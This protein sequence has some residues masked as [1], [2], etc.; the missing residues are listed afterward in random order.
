[1]TDQ[2]G[3]MV[4]GKQPHGAVCVTTGPYKHMQAV[5]LLKKQLQ[6]CFGNAGAVSTTAEVTP[7]LGPGPVLPPLARA[8]G[9][10]TGVSL[11]PPRINQVETRRSASANAVHALEGCRVEDVG[12]H[13]LIVKYTPVD[14]PDTMWRFC[15]STLCD[16]PR[17]ALPGRRNR[18][19]PTV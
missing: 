17:H 15:S 11:S 19:C 10:I 7:L 14:P 6:A 8:G 4:C 12:G 1:M 18:L 13:G 16:T 5:S 3:A 9:N 2:T